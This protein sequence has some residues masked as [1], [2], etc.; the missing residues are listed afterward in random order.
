[1]QDNFRFEHAN[2]LEAFKRIFREVGEDP[3]QGLAMIDAIQRLGID[4]HFQYENE[5]VMQ[6]Q[7][8]LY[9]TNGDHNN[10]LHEVALRFRLLRQ[11]GY[12]VAEGVQKCKFEP[13]YRQG[14]LFC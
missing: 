1:M 12:F 10:D 13:F 7:C 6:K 8:V 9:C 2:K 11:E 4:H 5:K 14:N 3:L